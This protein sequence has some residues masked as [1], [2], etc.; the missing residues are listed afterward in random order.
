ME[1]RCK[2]GH[3]SRTHPSCFNNNGEPVDG[4]ELQKD[5]KIL[6]FDIETLPLLAYTWGAWEQNVNPVQLVKDWCL[7]SYSAKWLNSDSVISNVLTPSEAK[8][9]NDK[10]ITKEVWR[11]I[12]EADI[13]IGHN[14][15]RFD[16]KKLNTRFWKH[17]MPVPGSYK[18]IDTLT[19]A[20][21]VF[22]ITYNKLDYIA[23]F[24]G[25]QKKLDTDFQLWKDCDSGV[26]KALTK[27][28]EYNDVD[29]IIQE[30]IYLEMRSWI[31]NHP[32]MTVFAGVNGA[33]PICLKAG[34][35]RI[36]EYTARKKQYPEYRCS[37]GAIWHSSKFVK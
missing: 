3:S 27:M 15:R 26:K 20:R 10:R 32:D 37:C 28:R 13:I 29:A 1:A 9:R 12:D 18:H 30:K 35:K 33:C 4:D 2:H 16:I 14:S 21:S 25:I 23:E 6:S 11:L 24:I 5:V 34:S 7:L 36:G 17:N 31:P 19:S 22:G 8:R